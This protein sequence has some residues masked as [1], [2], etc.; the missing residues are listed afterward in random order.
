MVT[1]VWIVRGGGNGQ[2][3]GQFLEVGYVGIGYN[4]HNDDLSCVN[5]PSELRSLYSKNISGADRGAKSRNLTRV[6]GF[7]F[8]MQIDD[9]VVTPT[10]HSERLICGRIA[11]RPYRDPNDRAS[12]N[13]L[14]RRRVIWHYKSIRRDE[15]FTLDGQYVGGVAEVTDPEHLG[16]FLKIIGRDDLIANLDA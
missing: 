5:D 12:N 16:T 7:L 10:P 6:E 3:T 8:E 9:Y 11:S 15:M 4:L 14:N 2:F 1:K 13:Y